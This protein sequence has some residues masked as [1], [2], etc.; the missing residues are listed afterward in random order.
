MSNEPFTCKKLYMNE[1][2]SLSD[3]DNI[4]ILPIKLQVMNSCRIVTGINQ[5]VTK[6]KS[7]ETDCVAYK[8]DLF[9]LQMLP[10]IGFIANCY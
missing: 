10:V 9:R 1:Q 3:V 8:L 7:L 4:E 6:R 2:P 5:E